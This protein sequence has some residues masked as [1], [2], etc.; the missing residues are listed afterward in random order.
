MANRPATELEWGLILSPDQVVLEARLS[1]LDC[2]IDVIA[3]YGN[4]RISANMPDHLRGGLCR[5]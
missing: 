3:E 2:R 5:C 4:S 1:H